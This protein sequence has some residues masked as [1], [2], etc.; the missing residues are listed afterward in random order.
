MGGIKST[1]FGKRIPTVAKQVL[2]EVVDIYPADF[3]EKYDLMPLRDMLHTLH[4]PEEIADTTIAKKT[5]FFK[6]LLR[7]QLHSL[8]QKQLYQWTENHIQQNIDRE[9]I[10]QFTST[11]PFELTNAQKK[12]LKQIIENIHE[13]KAMLRL[14]QWDVWSWKTVVAAAAAWYTIQKFWWQVAVLAPLA[15]LA[16]QHHKTLAKLLLPLWISVQLITWATKKAEKEKI[17][18]SLYLWH[19]QVIIWTHALLQDDVTFNNLQLAVIDEQHKFW[20][21]QRAY[22]QRH[23][24]PHLLQM[25]ATP[26]PRSMALAFFGEF[27]VSIIDEMPAGR[28]PITTKIV[29]ESE[30]HKLKPRILTKIQQ[31]QKVFIISPLI[32]ESDAEWFEHIKAV[33]TLYGEI[34]TMFDADIEKIKSWAYN[35]DPQ[36]VITEKNA[37]QPSEASLT[38][39]G[40]RRAEGFWNKEKNV[41]NLSDVPPV[42]RV[43]RSERSDDHSGGFSN[44]WLLHGKIKPAEK[45]QIMHNFKEGKTNILVSTTVIEVGIDIPDAT[46]MIIYN[47]ERFGLSQLHQLRGRVGRSDIQSYCFLETKKKTGDTYQRLKHMENITDGFK[48]A[49]IDLQYRGPGEFL[50]TRQSGETDI[51]LEILTDTRLTE[52]AQIAAKDLLENEPE[53]VK[54]VLDVDELESLLV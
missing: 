42:K 24:S 28:K 45:D 47:A 7:V 17:K 54:K 34:R 26:I 38:K 33:K 30:F 39:G 23:W 11:L 16:Q 8:V 44:I 29:A 49:E 13:P 52:N 53:V 35:T 14:L 51:P 32:E 2:D 18:Q 19:I 4:Y 36:Q 21:R 12:A 9:L 31:G 46:V 10:K 43:E 40:A 1:W 15:V 20:V 37:H 6:R 22:L 48:L 27:E 3:Y 41:H 25:T 5:V 50:W